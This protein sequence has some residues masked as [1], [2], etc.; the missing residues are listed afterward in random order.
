[1]AVRSNCRHNCIPTAG[2]AA[3]TWRNQS[4]CIT[5][6]SP[7]PVP[8][9]LPRW[10]LRQTFFNL[11]NCHRCPHYPVFTAFLRSHKQ[12]VKRRVGPSCRRGQRWPS[13][14]PLPAP[15]CPG[16]GRCPT[17]LRGAAPRAALPGPT[18]ARRGS[19]ERP[20]GRRYR[21]S[22]AERGGSASPN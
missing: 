17:A 14:R 2:S 20:R 8:V 10:Y 12:K 11:I 5:A 9:Y 16:R 4:E 13:E 7:L 19:A 18:S 1:M 15:R 22:P 3:F 21:H 6:R